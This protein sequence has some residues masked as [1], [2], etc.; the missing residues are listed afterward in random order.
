[1]IPAAL[2]KVDPIKLAVG[3]VIVIGV[4]YFLGRKTVKD[5]RDYV[6][7][8]VSSIN[9]GTPYEGTGVVGT[10]GHGVNVLTGNWLDDFGSWIGGSIY[11][12]THKG[13]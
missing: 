4:V 12:M 1:M 8:T 6:A 2:A 5:T 7:D 10:L 11:D 3:A 9:E 13:K